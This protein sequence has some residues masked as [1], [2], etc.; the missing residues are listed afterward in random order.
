MINQ[1]CSLERQDD[2]CWSAIL[3]P[4]ENE[5]T[6]EKQARIARQHEANRISNEIDD[7]IE[8]SRK[9]F[10]KRKKA[11]K[12]LLLGTPSLPTIPSPSSPTGQ[13]ESGKSTMLRSMSL[14]S[15]PSPPSSVP[16]SRLSARLLPHLLPSRDPNMEGHHTAQPHRVSSIL[17]CPFFPHSSLHSS[18]KKLL[19]IIDEELDSQSLRSRPSRSN[20]RERASP[21]PALPASP[22]DQSTAGAAFPRSAGPG[23]HPSSRSASIASSSAI[24]TQSSFDLKHDSKD[25][26][27]TP[28]HSA[29]RLRLLPLLSVETN[30]A[31]QLLPEFGGASPP[32]STSNGWT[33][34]ASGAGDHSA[35]VS[36]LTSGEICVRAGGA[37]KSIL[38]RISGTPRNS[39]D[40]QQHTL[41][42]DSV[43]HAIHPSSPSASK[44]TTR[45]TRHHP[46]DP[47]PL[48]EA[49]APDIH[50]LW[51]DPAVQALL[52]RKGVHM[53]HSAGFFLND[54]MR[55]GKPG[56]KPDI[57]SSP[58]TCSRP[59]SHASSRRHCTS[60]TQDVWGRGT[61]IHGR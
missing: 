52:K 47:T 1:R 37:W 9:Q 33:K 48:L 20:L 28:A 8:K 6:E 45:S 46:S 41:T 50:A 15:R 54:I 56:W 38:E 24:P 58:D 13:A 60:E 32:L 5:S 34:W 51:A 12:V 53:E 14:P 57:G 27:L 31:R 36:L 19:A 17:S 43:S 39:S 26:P 25:P 4:P 44:H 22:S 10:E 49:L 11:I 35:N 30:L 7:N 59:C 55:I 3:K 16:L 29:L 21:A 18:V 23:Q 40:T 42:H 2:D 61:Q